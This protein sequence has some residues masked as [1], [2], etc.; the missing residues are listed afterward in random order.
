MPPGHERGASDGEHRALTVGAHLLCELDSGNYAVVTDLDGKWRA[1]VEGTRGD[2]SLEGVRGY[3]FWVGY[4]KG[5][6]DKRVGIHDDEG[7][8]HW[9]NLTDV[10]PL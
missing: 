9:V 4:S 5:G 2:R 6:T 7:S 8:T 10:V 3:V 1:V